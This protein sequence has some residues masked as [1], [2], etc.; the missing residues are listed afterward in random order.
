VLYVLMGLPA[1]LT[2]YI[3]RTC[4]VPGDATATA[5]NITA[6]GLTYRIGVLS[7]LVSIR[8]SSQASSADW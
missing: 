6:A 2:R 1:V 7:M 3:T 4:I 5:R 8:C